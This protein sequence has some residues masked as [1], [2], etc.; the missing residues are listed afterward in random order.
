MNYTIIAILKQ[1]W[2]LTTVK[3]DLIRIRAAIF[4]YD[5]HF[6]YNYGVAAGIIF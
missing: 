2:L 1:K 3:I 6:L 4:A 5:R